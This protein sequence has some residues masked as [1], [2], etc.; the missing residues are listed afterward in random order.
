MH[1]FHW[2]RHSLEDLELFL[3]IL[4]HL[5]NRSQ[6]ITT[7]AVIRC[8]PHRHQILVLEPMDIALLDQLMRPGDQLQPIVV[9]EVIGN[10]W[11]EHPSCSSGVDGPIL[12][13]LGIGPHQIAEWSLMGN[14]DSSVDGSD[15]IDC[16]YF[17][18]ETS[19]NTENF[20]WI[21]LIVPSMTAPMGR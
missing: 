19:V 17:W 2:L 13:I 7:V 20:A 18:G 16:F 6:I 11:A 4:L 9:T 5:H 10:F 21:D 14:L 15:L 8:R 1:T 12:D 3:P